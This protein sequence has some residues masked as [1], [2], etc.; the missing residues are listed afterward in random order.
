MDTEKKQNL[1]MYFMNTMLYYIIS[2]LANPLGD[3]PCIINTHTFID[4]IERWTGKGLENG[5]VSP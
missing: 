5:G 1:I 2:Q 3:I 4:S